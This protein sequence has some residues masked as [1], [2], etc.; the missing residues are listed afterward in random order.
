[1]A[2]WAFFSFLAMVPGIEAGWV[3]EV[4][5]ELLVNSQAG[6]PEDAEDAIVLLLLRSLELLDMA[7]GVN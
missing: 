7:R 6:G 4:E 5:A 2:F 1:M 3:E